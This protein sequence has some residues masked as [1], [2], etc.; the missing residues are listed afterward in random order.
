MRI[1]LNLLQKPGR[2]VVEYNKDFYAMLKLINRNYFLKA[3]I[4][5]EKHVI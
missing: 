3:I 5:R 4:W 2:N 1:T